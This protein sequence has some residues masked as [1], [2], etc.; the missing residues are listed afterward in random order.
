MKTRI[1]SKSALSFRLNR[2]RGALIREAD[3]F[4]SAVILFSAALCLLLASSC[5]HLPLEP[6]YSG[7]EALP[8]T[9]E[10]EY[11]HEKFN[12]SARETIKY[13][14]E[15][16]R[17]WKVEFAPG[18]NILDL[19]HTISIDYYQVKGAPSSPAVL[20]LPILGGRNTAARIFADY[21]ARNGLAALIVH[22]QKKYKEITDINKLDKTLRQIVL[23]HKQALDWLERR[24]EVD[25]ERIGVFGVSMGGIKSALLAALESRIKASV[26][27]LGAGDLPYVLTYSKE[28]GVARRRNKVLKK[29]GLSLEQFY[30]KLKSE[31]TCDPAN[32]APYIDA[33]NTLMILARF[34]DAVPYEKGEELREKIGGPE[35][36]YLLS[37]HY[38]S[39]VFINYIKLA[40]LTFFVE[41]LS[42]AG[43]L[44][45]N[46]L[47]RKDVGR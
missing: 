32:Y 36:I 22:R 2:F 28:K 18:Q 23:D 37:G 15:F 20:V 16:Y 43:S 34:D 24:P 14:N 47:T 30:K 6:S 46:A 35:T 29:N 19:D 13:E 39:V 4:S 17:L 45:Q 44:Q 42:E 25:A 10:A 7:P 8:E 1:E 21:F 33:R 9:I 3:F 5:A 27:A 31:I 11:E 41:K 26:I 40:S 38:G 12:G